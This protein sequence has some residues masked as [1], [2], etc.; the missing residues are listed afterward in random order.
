MV[1]QGRLSMLDFIDL[2]REFLTLLTKDGRDHRKRVKKYVELEELIN[3]IQT[4]I[5]WRGIVDR[6]WKLANAKPPQLPKTLRRPEDV[7]DWLFATVSIL[8]HVA[9][10]KE[11]EDGEESYPASLQPPSGAFTIPIHRSS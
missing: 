4:T 1:S 6:L 11:M 9:R 3:R 7:K 5:D 10:V 8:E 2:I